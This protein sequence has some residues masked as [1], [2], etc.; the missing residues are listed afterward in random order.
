MVGRCTT[1]PVQW[2][3]S[4]WC[5]CRQQ[6]L[7]LEEA[8]GITSCYTFCKVMNLE[9][10]V[11]WKQVALGD[12]SYLQGSDPLRCHRVEPMGVSQQEAVAVIGALPARR[13]CR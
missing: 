2:P 13:L 12:P 9:R 1:S 11:S 7:K 10:A 8:T 4:A 6:S 5:G 3:Q